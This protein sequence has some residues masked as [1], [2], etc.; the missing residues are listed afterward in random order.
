MDYMEFCQKEDGEELISEEAICGRKEWVKKIVMSVQPLKKDDQ[1]YEYEHI[2]WPIKEFVETPN[3]YKC[4]ICVNHPDTALY[5]L[6][7]L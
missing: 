6:K 5:I 4:P 2:F 3:V 7:E 1:D